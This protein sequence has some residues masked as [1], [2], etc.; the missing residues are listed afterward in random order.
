MPIFNLRRAKFFTALLLAAWPYC[1]RGYAA[2][3]GPF[4]VAV[5]ADLNGGYGSCE[6]GEP[7]RAAVNAIVRENPGL[8][9]LAGDMVAGGKPSIP[10]EQLGRMWAAFR[11]AVGAPLAK[12]GIP[13]AP[14]PGNHDASAYPGHERE[15]LLYEK[16]WLENQPPLRYLDAA[17][18]PF[19]YAFSAGG[20]LFVVLDQTTTR[21]LTPERLAWLD[22]ILARPEFKAKVV[23]AHVPLFPFTRGRETEITADAELEALLARRGVSVVIS[24]H[25]HAYYPGRRGALR[26][27]GAGCLGDGPRKLIGDTKTSSRSFIWLTLDPGGS[28]S[29]EAAPYPDFS[30]FIGRG[31]LPVSVGTGDRAYERDDAA[32]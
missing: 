29:V 15:R 17:R 30:S 19:E 6:Y 12:A 26:Y 10:A 5:M 9:L 7:V 8:V 1:V 13:L 23:I 4:R 32:R 3:P 22:R 24:G 18:Y 25:H 20:A 11:G 31:E 14:A 28:V 2:S 21:G 27:A 16:E